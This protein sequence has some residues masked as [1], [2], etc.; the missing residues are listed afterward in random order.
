[1][2]REWL[3]DLFCVGTPLCAAFCAV[4]GVILAVLLLTIGLWKTLFIA[5]FALV[6]A[7]LGGVSDKCGAFR[8]FV[9]RSF[10]EKKERNVDTYEDM[11]N[12]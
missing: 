4:L 3:S 8:R 7:L 10:P 12:K 2:K 5:A 6:G 1:M 11:K 9:N